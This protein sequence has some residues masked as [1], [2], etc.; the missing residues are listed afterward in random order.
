MKSERMFQNVQSFIRPSI[1]TAPLLTFSGILV[2]YLTLEYC[3]SLC[4]ILFVETS[5]L[6][7]GVR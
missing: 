7:N 2:I 4:L 1:N 5:E 6:L 3:L